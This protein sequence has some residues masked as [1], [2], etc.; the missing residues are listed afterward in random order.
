MKTDHVT[1]EVTTR[2]LFH[3][4]KTHDMD[5]SDTL[6]VSWGLKELIAFGREPNVTQYTPALERLCKAGGEAGFEAVLFHTQEFVHLQGF[7]P[8]VNFTKVVG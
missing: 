8:Q 7:R 2:P 4:A 6:Q 5:Y 1:P 3:I